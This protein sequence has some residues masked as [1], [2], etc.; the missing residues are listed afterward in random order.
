MFLT[1]WN[2]FSLEKEAG[3]LAMPTYPKGI[4]RRRTH[5]MVM[6]LV[7]TIRP[8]TMKLPVISSLLTCFLKARITHGFL[9]RI[10]CL[11]MT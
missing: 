4:L 2:A 8:L 7:T 3:Q 9:H 10:L 1:F 6:C 5:L 11:A